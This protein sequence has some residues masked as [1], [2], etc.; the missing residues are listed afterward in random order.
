MIRKKI[1]ITKNKYEIFFF[2]TSGER[3]KFISR[4]QHQEGFITGPSI[5]RV[6]IRDSLKVNFS[7]I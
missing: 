3:D 4:V 1:I 5:V 2:A 7:G 6:A